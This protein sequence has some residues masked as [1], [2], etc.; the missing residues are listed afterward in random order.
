MKHASYVGRVGALAVAL[1]VG[2]AMAGGI[3]IA[4]AS[5]SS[6]GSSASAGTSGSA[7]AH[8]KPA[9]RSAAARGQSS[10]GPRRPVAVQIPVPTAATSV[11]RPSAAVGRS[12]VLDIPAGPA[13]AAATVSGPAAASNAATSAQT[14]TTDSGIMGWFRRAFFNSTPVLTPQAV[15]VTLAAGQTSQPFTLAGT[16][17]D[18]DTLS[19]SV[20]NAGTGISGGTLVTS[21]GTATYTPPSSWDGL[22]SYE[23]TFTVTASDAGNGFQIHGLSGLLSMLTFG[24]LG[25]SGQTATSTVTVH[26]TPVTSANGNPVPSDVVGLPGEPFSTSVTGSGGVIYQ[27]S[28]SGTAATGYRTYVTIV[29]PNGTST[30]VSQAGQAYTGVV[31]AANG[32][33]YQISSS[34]GPGSIDYSADTTVLRAVRPD[35]TVVDYTQ[36][37]VIGSGSTV[38]IG[39]DGSI[40]ATSTAGSANPGYTT[41]VRT[42]RADGTTTTHTQ[43]GEAAG[44]IVV[45]ADGTAYQTSFVYGTNMQKSTVVDVLLPGGS[46]REYTMAGLPDGP[47]VVRSGGIAYQTASLWNESAG[48]FTTT[49]T[50]IRPDGTSSVR[51]GVFGVRPTTVIAGD[52]TAYQT[53]ASNGT[54]VT[55]VAPGGTRVSKSWTGAPVGGVVIGN[56]GYAYQASVSNGKTTVTVVRPDG[57]VALSRVQNG[58]PVTGLVLGGD[59]SVYA[60]S[61]DS[62]AGTTLVNQFRP[63]GSVLSRS[64]SGQ[65]VGGLVVLADGRVY[66]TTVTGNAQSGYTT[67]TRAWGADGTVTDRTQSGQAVGGVVVAA[68]GTI[69]QTSSGVNSSGVATAVV[70]V[71]ATDGTTV[72]HTMAGLPSG[73][74][75]IGTDGTAY[76]TTSTGVWRVDTQPA[77]TETVTDRGPL[78]VPAGAVDATAALQAILDAAAPGSTL[79]LQ[80]GRTY[81]VAGILYLRNA[82]VTVDGNGATINSTNDATSS[83]QITANG[84]TLQ[85]VNLTAATEGLRYGTLEQQKLVVSGDHDTVRNVSVTGSAAAGIFAYGAGNFTLDHDTVR[86][87]RADGIHMTGGSHDGTVINPSTAWTEDDGVA[88]VSYTGEPISQN[89]VI[90]NPVIKGSDGRGIAVVGGNNVT[91]SNIY[92]WRS[93]AAA[94]YVAAEGA[95][96]YSQSVSNVTIKGGSLVETATSTDVVQGAILVYSGSTSATVST[97]TISDLTV[98]G[99]PQYA[100]RSTGI[101]QDSGAGRISGVV[102]KNIA[103]ADTALPVFAT[104]APSSSYTA[105]GFT[106][107]GQPVT[108]P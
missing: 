86:Y 80:R 104:N 89:I 62:V 68:D 78:A 43:Q 56:D 47:V 81:N 38:V 63:D 39:P 88:V 5:P 34:G 61:Y 16:D 8:G 73:A 23:D 35:G 49:I 50:A 108:V 48:S 67:L 54:T 15:P 96:W 12:R 3:A 72:R 18:G 9:P 66:Q 24:L 69:Y 106:L 14:T 57:N 55:V 4:E 11:P 22:T 31:V 7:T 36:P 92:V 44:P 13:P 107:N 87:T 95:P 77:S 99:T 85:N 102:L 17:A 101:I 93:R 30:T 21:G 103:L 6:D 27:T 71:V 46:T 10:A 98:T 41:V 40:Y 53:T 59:G 84:V 42:V 91:F 33:A 74:V 45:G 76:V 94:V 1:G 82:S 25:S 32:T 97:V 51:T 26:V 105:T 90:T 20:A 2:G 100:G 60:A 52:G 28:V 37:G 83:V 58:S 29:R 65:P 64:Q 19:Y 70:T 75:T 79:R